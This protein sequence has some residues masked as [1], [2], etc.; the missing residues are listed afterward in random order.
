MTTYCGVDICTYFRLSSRPSSEGTSAP[1][2]AR[3]SGRGLLAIYLTS[4]R[5]KAASEAEIE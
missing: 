5:D 2:G 1:P 3:L 4:L